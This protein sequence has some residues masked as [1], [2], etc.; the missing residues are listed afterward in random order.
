MQADLQFIQGQE[1][2]RAAFE[3]PP[4]MVTKTEILAALLE[5]EALE[6]EKKIEKAAGKVA[7]DE[8]KKSFNFHDSAKRILARKKGGKK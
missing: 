7:A 5:R 6:L 2:Q 8:A 1:M 4:R 3:M